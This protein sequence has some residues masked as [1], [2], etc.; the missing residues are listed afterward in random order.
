MRAAHVALIEAHD[1]ALVVAKIAIVSIR[2]VS[3]TGAF[4]RLRGRDVARQAYILAAH[5]ID[6]VIFSLKLH[7]DLLRSYP[8]RKFFGI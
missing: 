4:R 5:G 7:K 1:A 3:G 6:S 8:R 2:R